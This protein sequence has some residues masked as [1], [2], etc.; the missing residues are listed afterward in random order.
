MV[1]HVSVSHDDV[2]C[3]YCLA[4]FFFLQAERYVDRALN[5]AEDVVNKQ[6]KKATKWYAAFTGADNGLRIND[7]H[8]FLLSF[9]AGV[10]IGIGSA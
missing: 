1:E 4:L 3:A 8:I 7:L 5:Q 2:T 6:R 10:A 9:A